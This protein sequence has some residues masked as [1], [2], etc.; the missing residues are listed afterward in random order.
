[1]LIYSFSFFR[2]GFKVGKNKSRVFLNLFIVF[3]FYI[4]RCKW[5]YDRRK[6][7]NDPHV[8]LEINATN[9]HSYAISTND[10]S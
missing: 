1:M 2:F 10:T 9:H 7:R 3:F 5:K 4:S 6:S 8:E